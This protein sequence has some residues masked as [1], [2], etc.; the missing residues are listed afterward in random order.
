MNVEVSRRCLDVDFDES[1]IGTPPDL[2]LA[3]FIGIGPKVDHKLK[4][5]NFH[6]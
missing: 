3:V 4:I 2:R 5:L 6:F 1:R